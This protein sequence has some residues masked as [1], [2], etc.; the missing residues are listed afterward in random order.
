MSDIKRGKYCEMLIEYEYCRNI[1]KHYFNQNLVMT[2]E[3]E[4]IFQASDKCWICG[5]SF[6]DNSDVRVRDHCHIFG[7][8]RGLHIKAVILILK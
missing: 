5:K 3:D 2:E 8:F 4:R 1:K 6:D 7:K